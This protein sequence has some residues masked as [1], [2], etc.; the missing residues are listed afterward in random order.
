M[1]RPDLIDLSLCSPLQISLRALRSR[2]CARQSEK[3]LYPNERQAKREGREESNRR[4]RVECGYAIPRPRCTTTPAQGQDSARGR[5]F[6][7]SHLFEGSR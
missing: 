5:N 1:I 3:T 6:A 2:A 7:G 4:R